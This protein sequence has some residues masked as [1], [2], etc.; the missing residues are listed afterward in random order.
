[1]TLYNPGKIKLFIGITY[2]TSGQLKNAQRWKMQAAKLAASKVGGSLIDGSFWWTYWVSSN[3][4]N[5]YS[6]YR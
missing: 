4:R 3:R 5:Q 1:M 6:Y 2:K